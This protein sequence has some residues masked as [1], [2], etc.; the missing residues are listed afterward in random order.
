MLKKSGKPATPSFPA[1]CQFPFADGRHCRMP[2]APSHPFLCLFHADRE[3]RFHERACL[4]S[5]PDEVAAQLG[6]F[7]GEIKTA[8]D[9]NVLLTRLWSL[10]ASRRIPPRTA[11]TLAYLANLLLQTLGPV[12]DEIS[13][14]R[15]IEE[16]YAAVFRSFPH[17]QSASRSPANSD[18]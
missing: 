8:N 9:L 1:T 15:G 7:S 16:W 13:D 12:R 18:S 2:I 5:A 6:T 11:A 14:T 4:E 17:R 10:V 3:R